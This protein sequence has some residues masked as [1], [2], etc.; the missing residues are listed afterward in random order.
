MWHND[1]SCLKVATLEVYH[2]WISYLSTWL[3]WCCW[4]SGWQRSSI[5]NSTK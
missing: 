4:N 5:G 2:L 3:S 1:F